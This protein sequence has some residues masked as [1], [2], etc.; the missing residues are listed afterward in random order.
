[1]DTVQTVWEFYDG[2]RTGIADFRGKPCYFRCQWDFEAGAYSN[3]YTLFPVDAETLEL[4]LEQWDI[5]RQWEAA[6][7]AGEAPASS[8]PGNGGNEWYAELERRLQARLSDF[9]TPQFTL[10]AQFHTVQGGEKLPAGIMRPLL[11]EW[12]DAP[13]HSPTRTAA[14]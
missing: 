11:V 9:T 2:P 12:D 7:H 14:G 1:M 4:A 8:H 6:F 5:W 13:N 10:H 3:V